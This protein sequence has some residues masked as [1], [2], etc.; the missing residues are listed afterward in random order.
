MTRHCTGSWCLPRHRDGT[1][2]ERWTEASERGR[3]DELAGFGGLVVVAV[4][5][6]ITLFT[7]PAV[8]QDDDAEATIEALQ[9]RVAELEAELEPY[10]EG[11]PTTPAIEDDP[12]PLGDEFEL[13][14]FYYGGVDGDVHLYGEIRNVLQEGTVAPEIVFSFLDD[15]GVVIGTEEVPPLW[16]W[17][18][19]GATMPFQTGSLLGRALLPED[20]MSV[21]VSRGDDVYVSNPLRI[22]VLASGPMPESGESLEGRIVNTGDGP[23]SGV[24]IQVARYDEDGYYVG[25]CYDDY[26][27]ITIQPGKFGRFSFSGGDCGIT[28][29]GKAIEEAMD[30]TPIKSS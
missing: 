23:V 22:D 26:L 21:D 14:Y 2:F 8:A 16:G 20:W 27:D 5:L 30:P 24:S 28:D 19:G 12:I 9:T 13:L 18:A 15:A 7:A 25:S 10:S 6:A 1:T 17:V 3:T 11:E 4:V 29:A